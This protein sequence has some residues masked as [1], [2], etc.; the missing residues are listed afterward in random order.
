M[1]LKMLALA[2]IAALY[3]CGGGNSG[4]SE[5]PIDPIP[6]INATFSSVPVLL[7][8]FQ[9]YFFPVEKR[10]LGAQPMVS[11]VDLNNDG[12]KDLVVHMWCG[13]GG[14]AMGLPKSDPTDDSLA[15]FLQ[16]PDGSF[17][18]ANEQIFGTANVRFYAAS[19]KVIVSD[20]NND[21]YPDLA[22]AVNREDGREVN[23]DTSSQFATSVVMLSQGNGKYKV[24][25]LGTPN[26]F[27]SVEAV[28]TIT[29]NDVI[30]AGFSGPKQAFRFMD[31]S[32]VAVSDQYPNVS[33]STFRARADGKTII[34]NTDNTYPGNPASLAKY[35][36][37]N[38]VWSK[39][40]ERLVTG[41]FVSYLGWNNSLGSVFATNVGTDLHV[42]AGYDESCFLKINPNETIFVGK[43][44]A[45]VLTN[46]VSGT[47]IVQNDTYNQ[48]IVTL[49]SYKLDNLTNRLPSIIENEVTRV[50]FNYMNCSDVNADGYDDIVVYPLW[51]NMAES[52]IVYLNNKQG[53]LVKLDSSIF[54]AAQYN[55]TTS[56]Y[57][58]FDNDGVRDLLYWS[59][60]NNNKPIL[61]KGKKLLGQ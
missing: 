26:W 5:S 24:D 12:K 42:A 2:I 39:T 48:T 7:P 8:P 4:P 25:T 38:G 35:E 16:R 22:Y 9:D 44:N 52:I 23:S 34:T 43:Y 47:T 10:C 20:F 54:P 57:E 1:K 31:G 45:A 60:S 11:A 37:I 19:R 40:S 28:K 15:V 33:A 36:L 18:Y 56:L 6:E 14:E 58:D 21:G 13:V 55:N 46:Y 29:G 61:F 41:T 3:G 59:V 49:N 32:W 17:K 53:K 27:H 50:N 51:Q 30:F